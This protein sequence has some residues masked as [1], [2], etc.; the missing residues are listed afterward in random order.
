MAVIAYV[1][2]TF[3]LFGF[4]YWNLSTWEVGRFRSL[5]E[6]QAL[7][8]SAYLEGQKNLSLEDKAY[9]Q[10]YRLSVSG[11]FERDG[12]YAQGNLHEIPSSLLLDGKAHLILDPNVRSKRGFATQ[13]LFVGTRLPDQRILVIGR[14]TPEVAVLEE[15]VKRVF[16]EGVFP[17]SLV[18]L[19]IGAFSSRKMS[20]RL[21][22]AQQQ[23]DEIKRGALHERLTISNSNDEL[24][25]LARS[26]NE[27]LA[28]L[29][30]AMHELEHVGNNIAH[31]LR[32]PLGRVRAHLEQVQ[33]DFVL[34]LEAQGRIEQ[35]LNNLD[36]S[37]NATT[38][39]LRVAH[40]E[41][42]STDTHFSEFDVSEMLQELVE[43]Y[44]PAAECKAIELVVRNET[45]EFA[46]GDRDLLLEAFANLID[47]AVKFTPERGMVEIRVMSTLQG[48]I[49]EI[50][51][52]GP[53]IPANQRNQVF[54]RFYRSRETRHAAGS[55]LGLTLVA[56]I[57]RLH[58]FEVE[59]K[60]ADRGCAFLVQLFRR[61]R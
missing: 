56:A 44:Q 57:I 43:L 26:V 32:T 45:E 47:N 53:G 42:G 28:Q 41:A 20:G 55:G 8:I 1:M 9:N 22:A 38:A 49:V 36:Q 35:A 13:T 39:L 7:G 34:P 2:G 5:L 46:R 30:A 29:E 27:M 60:D 10:A 58:G 18:A 19:M 24:D 11:L 25:S 33:S 23:L 37:L 48:P 31:D 50:H 12:S 52:S 16:M 21:R 40:F 61:T 15:A 51:D 4:L 3:V 6:L 59:I 14:E 54:K 17:F